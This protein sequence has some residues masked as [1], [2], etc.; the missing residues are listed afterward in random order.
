MLEHDG[1][2]VQPYCYPRELHNNIY[3]A[4]Q[5]K[6]TVKTRGIW[7]GVIVRVMVVFRKT[8]VND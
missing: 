6:L 1:T 3:N 5:E 8:F 7:I 4:I 2:I